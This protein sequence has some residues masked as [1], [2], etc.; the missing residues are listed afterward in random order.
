MSELSFYIRVVQALDEI[1]APYMIV[2]SFA[3]YAFG[4]THATLDIDTVFHQFQ[5]R[6]KAAYFCRDF[7][8]C[9]MVRVVRKSQKM[10]QHATRN[11]HHVFRSFCGVKVTN[12]KKA[13]L[14]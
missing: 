6:L 7:Q 10:T 11:T 8:F 12:R 13:K 9:C 5:K 2:G 14:K 1:N 3:G 4:I